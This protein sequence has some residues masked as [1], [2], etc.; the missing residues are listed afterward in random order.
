MIVF[1]IGV[2]SLACTIAYANYDDAKYYKYLSDS[3][4]KDNIELEI[5]NNSLRN[6]LYL[7]QQANEE[8]EE[9]LEELKAKTDQGKI[10]LTV[11]A[12]QVTEKIMKE[13]NKKIEEMK[14]DGR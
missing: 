7:E 5:E 8:L 6:E 13:V 4:S 14:K 1:I 12:R 3:L 10:T 11:D 9:E 2:L